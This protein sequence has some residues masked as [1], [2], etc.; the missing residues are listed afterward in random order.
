MQ[1]SLVAAVAAL[2][3]VASAHNHRHAHD[4]FKKNGLAATGEVCVPTC[5]TIWKTITG[6]ATRMLNPYLERAP[7]MSRH[8]SRK[9]TRLTT[10]LHD[11]WLLKWQ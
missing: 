2:A 10:N 4:L 11:N 6:E 5:T 1:G 9:S 7:W 3:G 8:G